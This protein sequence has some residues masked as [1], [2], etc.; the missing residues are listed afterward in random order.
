MDD[1]KLNPIAPL[2]SK[3][4]HISL[5]IAIS[6]L[7]V[8]EMGIHFGWLHGMFW[9][10]I[11]TGFEA[12]TVGALADWFA[13]SALFYKIPL[14]LIGKHT[15]IIAKNR[16]KL[17]EGIVELVTTKWLSSEIIREKLED[18]PIARG[19]F[20]MLENRA[21]LDRVLAFLR[22]LLQRFSENL[23]NPKFA[24]L[25]K[26]LMED[27]IKEADIAGPLA[28]WLK[29][30]VKGK[31]HHRMVDLLLLESSKVLDEPGT[32]RMIR[33]KL[34]HV[35]D[36]YGD[37]GRMKRLA[38]NIGKITGGLDLDLITDQLLELAKVMAEEIGLNPEHPLREKM[39]ESLLE[40][41]QNLE[42]GDPA[43]LE[44][45]DKLKLKFTEGEWANSL[46]VDVLAKLKSSFSE[47]LSDNDTV[48]ARI[49]H[50]NIRRLATEL[51][52]D[53]DTQNQLDE[54]LKRTVTQLLEKHHYEIGNMVRSSLLKLDD[55]GLVAQIQEKVGDDLQY[56]RLN[57]AVVGGLVGIVIALL[58]IVFFN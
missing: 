2:K 49:L 29:S 31:G 21:N 3:I 50:R 28:D 48:F 53:E 36:A 40:I 51:G 14:P 56:I 16:E 12:G 26:R 23:D 22:H 58:R 54:W 18:V 7:V 15:N 33:E 52:D 57:G 27:Q 46:I 8:T 38:I 20:A 55:R 5:I 4:G 42:E 39:D 44:Y 35:L 45:L 11:A 43:Y 9:R 10:V 25:A 37:K 1:P 19:V 34:S 13:V 41:A 6:G 47:Q 24:L 32:R 17:T 30:T